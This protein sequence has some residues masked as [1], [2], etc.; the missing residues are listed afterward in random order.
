MKVYLKLFVLIA[1]VI[2]MFYALQFSSERRTGDAALVVLSATIT[3][4]TDEEDNPIIRADIEV[5]NR[6]GR[7]FFEV[8][9]IATAG[10]RTQEKTLTTG[11]R[12]R[13]TRTIPLIFDDID[14]IIRN[15][16]FEFYIRPFN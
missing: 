2:G 8:G 10:N 7:G 11:M 3:E 6:G 12:R 13:S 4:L 14:I 16:E 5:R 15:P 1:I 9:G